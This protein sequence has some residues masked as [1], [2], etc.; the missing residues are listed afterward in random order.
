M[1][2][3]IFCNEVEGVGEFDWAAWCKEKI[4]PWT[5]IVWLEDGLEYV[6]YL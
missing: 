6:T 2:N 3:N 4:S 1:T 5:F